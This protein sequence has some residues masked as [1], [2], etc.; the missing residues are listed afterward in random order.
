MATPI[1]AEVLA[2]WVWECMLTQCLPRS[3]CA[4]KWSHCAKNPRAT[5][6]TLEGSFPL[7]TRDHS[8]DV[9]HKKGETDVKW[10]NVCCDSPP[11]LCGSI[12]S[13]PRAT[14]QSLLQGESSR[15]CESCQ[16][17]PSQQACQQA[18]RAA[19]CSFF[20]SLTIYIFLKSPIF[21]LTLC[22]F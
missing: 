13:T 1:K 18:F 7:G 2:L 9:W 8:E 3:E 11:C 12:K 22:N 21:F 15:L 20:L 10:L 16:S 6:Q 14:P 4:N 5:P 19:G 17:A